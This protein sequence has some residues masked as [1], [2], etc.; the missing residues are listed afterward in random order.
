MTRT[1]QQEETVSLIP[2][3]LARSLSFLSIPVWQTP[4]AS[5]VCKAPLNRG[6]K[7]SRLCLRLCRLV[8][9]QTEGLK[10]VES[11]TFIFPQEAVT[12]TH[13]CAI[14]SIVDIESKSSHSV[15]PSGD[16]KTSGFNS[17]TVGCSSLGCS[18]QA[19]TNYKL[20]L[21]KWHQGTIVKSKIK[22]FLSK[23]IHLEK[24]LSGL[25]QALLQFCFKGWGLTSLQSVLSDDLW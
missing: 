18:S 14:Q 5:V 4:A 17:F 10:Q 24:W 1:H 15:R 9:R 12:H 22:C 13:A 6:D 7:I 8:Y 25:S 19:R 3:W 16:Q 23:C 21:I 20:T 2:R 11:P